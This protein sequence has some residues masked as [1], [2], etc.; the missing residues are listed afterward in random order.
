M[1]LEEAEERIRRGVGDLVDR[2]KS[3]GSQKRRK[4]EQKPLGAKPTPVGYDGAA[5]SS[6]PVKGPS[7]SAGLENIGLQRPKAAYLLVSPPQGPTKSLLSMSLSFS[8]PF[9]KKPQGRNGG[10]A[11]PKPVSGPALAA[12][13]ASTHAT[14]E[15]DDSQQELARNPTV[16]VYGDQ[17][18]FMAAKK[19]RQWAR[20]LESVP[21]SLFRAHEVSTAGHFWIEEGVL[22]IL[23]DAVRTFGEELLQAS[24]SP[25]AGKDG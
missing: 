21:G 14:A 9:A 23:Q 7:E 1:S 18:V 15:S 8:N 12:P 24:A 22:N 4:G 25:D 2:V 5:E 16:M 11:H 19:Q 13:A 20:G 6:R 10:T 3:P 17:D